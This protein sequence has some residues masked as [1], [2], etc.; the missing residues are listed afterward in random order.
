[1]SGPSGTC[2]GYEL[3]ANPDFDADDNGSTH[4]GG[5]GDAGDTLY[6]NGGAGW[7]PRG[8]HQES[9]HRDFTAT[10][11]GNDHTV[12]NLYMNL[13]TTGDNEGNYVGLFGDL[14]AA[15]TIR[16]VGLVDPYVANARGGAGFSR[17]G[18]LAGRNNGGT[19]SGN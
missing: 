19:A 8:G 14:A 11:E 5:A 12:S 10:F 18:A 16:N 2:A 13:A 3:R 9:T 4:T 15:A 1:M 17:T 6:Y 7:T